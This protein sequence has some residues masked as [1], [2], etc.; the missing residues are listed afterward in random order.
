MEAYAIIRKKRDGERLSPE[1]I[2]WFIDRYVAGEVADYQAAAW[3]MAAYLRGL[4]AG[5]TL[6]LTE[7]L[8]RSGEQVDL[9]GIRGVKVDKHSTGGVGDK[10]TLVLAPLLAAAGAKVA[11]MSGRGLGHTGG[12]IDKLEAIPGFRTAMERE[13]FV[14]QVNRTGVAVAAQTEKIVP[15]DR[16][17]YALRDVTATVDSIPLIAASVMAKKLA[18]GADV[19]VLDVKTGSGAF[20]QDAAAAQELA[21][22][23]VAIGKRAGRRVVALVT[24]MDQ[25]LGYAVGNAIEVAEAIA[26]LKG[27][28]PLD[29]TELCLELGSR[30]LCLGGLA[31]SLKTARARLEELL[32]G[33]QALGKFRE[34]VAAQGGDPRVVD[35]PELLPQAPQKIPVLSPRAGYVVQINAL[36]VGEAARA[37]GAGRRRKEEGV[38]P[39]VGV[40]LVAKT[41]SRVEAGEPL[42]YI[43]AREKGVAEAQELLAGAFTVAVNPPKTRPLV[44]AVVEK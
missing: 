42:A 9:S 21:R 43:L 24:D 39:A 30:A 34:W 27:R 31:V 4:D 8:A 38:D 25:P 41:G 16:K 12:T 11:K 40:L 19:I 20:M 17:L 14:A 13:E 10:T 5:E 29:L 1:E 7:A 26:T 22:L 28:G 6:A 2:S 44:C 37:L 33:G 18:C 23:M 35:E 36:A 15:A 3:L 32:L